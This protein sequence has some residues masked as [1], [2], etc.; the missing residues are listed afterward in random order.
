MSSGLYGLWERMRARCD[1]P[2]Y[3]GYPSV[4]GRGIRVCA[5][6]GSYQRFRDWAVDAGWM[7]GDAIV[8]VAPDGDYAPGNCRIVGPVPG[9]AYLIP[10]KWKPVRRD[11][12]ETF[13]SLRDA[14]MQVIGEG[15]S[16]ASVKCVAK[17]IG[18]AAN[19]HIRSA[20]GSGWEWA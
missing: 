5:E 11:T 3:P 15:R 7:P 13:S 10:G 16:T 18:M 9:A 2:H 20:Y 19:R 14:A 4:G 6:W 8:R 17:N 12:G 1:N